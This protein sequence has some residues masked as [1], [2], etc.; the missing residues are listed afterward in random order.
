MDGWMDGWM[1]MHVLNLRARC[2]HGLKGVCFVL[3][4]S[5]RTVVILHAR[6]RGK[7]GWGGVWR[8][9]SDCEGDDGLGGVFAFGGEEER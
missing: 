8:C 9:D 2:Q 5:G 4:G 3:N 6:E 1:I 7:T